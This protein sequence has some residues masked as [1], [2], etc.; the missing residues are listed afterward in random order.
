MRPGSSL[1]AAEKAGLPDA[2]HQ[3]P[4][5]GSCAEAKQCRGRGSQTLQAG[6]SARHGLLRQ[7]ARRGKARAEVPAPEVRMFQGAPPTRPPRWKLHRESPG[8]GPVGPGGAGG[9]CEGTHWPAQPEPFCGQC[10]ISPI[11]SEAGK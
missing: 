11:A 6:D 3:H 1:T 4:A 7:S 2:Q 10:P 8:I 9:R 5:R